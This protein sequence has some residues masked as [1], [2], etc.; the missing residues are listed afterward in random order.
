MLEVNTMNRGKYTVVNLSE[1]MD[2]V[3]DFVEN[4]YDSLYAQ[5][6]TI[7]SYV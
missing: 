6:L 2:L 7:T 5:S 1:T 3:Y 4:G